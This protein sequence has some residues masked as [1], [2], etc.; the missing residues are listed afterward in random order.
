MAEQKQ[1]LQGQNDQ[2]FRITVETDMVGEVVFD[3]EK[4]FI[5]EMKN[6]KGQ[7]VVLD[8]GAGKLIDSPGVALC[9]GLFK[10]CKAK[11]SAFSIEAGP[12]LFRFFKL[13]KLT[14]VIDIR[15][16]AGI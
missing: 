5:D 14:K 10:E 6:I 12:D 11:G 2:E 7:P 1:G 3:L 8:L 13:F 15:E 16:R 4:R 9:V